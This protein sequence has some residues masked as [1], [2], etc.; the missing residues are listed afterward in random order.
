[1]AV[2]KCKDCKYHQIFK[3]KRYDRGNLRIDEFDYCCIEP[4][5]MR[6]D[7]TVVACRHFV[8]RKENTNE[9]DRS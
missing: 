2:D 7:R 5:T 1:M 6:R 3:K 4:E 8:S 9:N